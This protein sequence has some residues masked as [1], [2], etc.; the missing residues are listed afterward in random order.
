MQDSLFINLRCLAKGNK[1]TTKNKAFL[2]WV[3]ICV[4]FILCFMFKEH[5][6]KNLI[7]IYLMTSLMKS[8]ENIC[9]YIG[10]EKIISVVAC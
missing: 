9:L 8:G 6:L 2:H 5:S 4:L 3:L 7:K 1:V 10:K